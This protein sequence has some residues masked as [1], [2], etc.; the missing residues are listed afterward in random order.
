MLYN[1]EATNHL[2][3]SQQI[4]SG[5]KDVGALGFFKSNRRGTKRNNFGQYAEVANNAT[6]LL[7]ADFW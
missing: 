1:V 2:E 6:I 5:K 7:L 4:P 3:R